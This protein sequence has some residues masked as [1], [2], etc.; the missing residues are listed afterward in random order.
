[1]ERETCAVETRGDVAVVTLNRPTRS[2][3]LDGA[4]WNDL[5]ECFQFCIE[6]RPLCVVLRGCGK[7]FCAGI[8]V[9]DVET[10]T[11][12]LG[13]GGNGSGCPGRARERLRAHI[14]SLQDVFSLLERIEA[15][16]IAC[17]QGACYGAGID[18]ITACD[19]RIAQRGVR[20]C[21][22][23]VD[24]GITADVGTLQRLT[25]IVGH[26]RA[27]ELALTAREFGD[28][29]AMRIG[30]VT[31]VSDDAF[32][33]GVELATALAKKSPLALRGTKRVLLKMR[34]E[35]DVERGLDYVATHNAAVLMS[36]D[37]KEAVKARFERR[38]PVFSKL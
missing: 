35:P 23:E 15:P 22:K 17:V 32:G 12:T 14:K 37:L 20:F 38:E 8:D 7:N 1:M 33:R 21:V 25:P 29:E 19:V 30:L 28:E 11:S 18:M 3:A 2:N 31:E 5:R 9:S 4:M 34:S 24:L 26:G 27:M 10:L 6:R 16:V 13:N 36:D